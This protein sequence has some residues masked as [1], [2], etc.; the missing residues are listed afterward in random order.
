M[1]IKE[2][3]IKNI[4]ING[5]AGIRWEKILYDI[6]HNPILRNYVASRT[7]T[8]EETVKL[9][10]LRSRSRPNAGAAKRADNIQIKYRY[11]WWQ[12]YKQD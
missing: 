9:N 3:E 1:Q 10:L 11:L 5:T 4:A 2:S 6:L 12:Y 8:N 7:G